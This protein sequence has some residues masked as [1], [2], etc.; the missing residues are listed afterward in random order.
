MYLVD[1]QSSDVKSIL[2]KEWWRISRTGWKELN[3]D[4]WRIRECEDT[5]ECGLYLSLY[6]QHCCCPVR[7]SIWDKRTSLEFAVNMFTYSRIFN[8]TVSLNN[9]YGVKNRNFM[10]H[11][12][13]T[14]RKIQQHVSIMLRTFFDTHYAV[15]D[16]PEITPT[17][18]LTAPKN[19]QKSSKT[20]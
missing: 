16:N 13:F 18:P 8:A 9:V 4:V 20:R 7:L 19:I 3:Q 12:A 11:R 5:E 14:S 1:F 15:T 6:I 2:A 17:E 10:F